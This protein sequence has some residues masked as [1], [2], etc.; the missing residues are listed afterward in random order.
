[1]IWYFKYIYGPEDA[2]FCLN[3]LTNDY[4]IS[5]N[6]IKLGNSGIYYYATTKLL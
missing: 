2:L 1:M 4:D 3:K 5:F 6:H